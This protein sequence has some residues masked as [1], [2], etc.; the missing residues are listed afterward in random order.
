MGS[1]M[2]IRDSAI[3]LRAVTNACGAL[4]LEIEDTGEGIDISEL[5]R[6]FDEY[7]RCSANSNG[8][9]LGL[10]I[11]ER[12]CKH[13]DLRVSVVSERFQGTCFTLTFLSTQFEILSNTTPVDGQSVSQSD[14]AVT[15]SGEARDVS[16]AGAV[17]PSASSTDCL[18]YTSPSP[19]DLSTSRMP[20]SA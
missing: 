5:E 14:P 6:V 3:T 16:K 19:R 15:V 10:S 18:L 2:C 1:E 20:S 7:H 4:V 12:L 11:V 9:G 8:L 13:L 17:H